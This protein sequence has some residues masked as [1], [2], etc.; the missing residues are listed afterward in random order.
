MSFKKTISILGSTG[1]VGS[2]TVDVINSNK[3]KFSVFS[4]SSKNNVNLLCK[5]ALLLKPKIVAIQN[6]KKYKDLRNN[7]ENTDPEGVLNGDIDR[8]LEAALYK[9]KEKNKKITFETMCVF[10]ANKKSKKLLK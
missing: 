8:F 5:Q 4:L 3:K 9:T 7:L 1:S 6:K 10:K 2:N